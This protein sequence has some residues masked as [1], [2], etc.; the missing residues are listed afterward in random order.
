MSVLPWEP[1]LGLVGVASVARRSR[2]KP[3]GESNGRGRYPVAETYQNGSVTLCESARGH[4]LSPGL[5]GRHSWRV[6]VHVWPRVVIIARA[7]AAIW[8]L[9]AERELP[10][11]ATVGLKLPWAAAAGLKLSD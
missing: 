6:C 10:W 2:E 3:A 11:V 8:V 4:A 5:L 1:R 9:A 7:V